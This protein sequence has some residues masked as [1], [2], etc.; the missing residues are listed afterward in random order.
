MRK[1][2][3]MLFLVLFLGCTMSTEQK[4]ALA[5]IAITAV[6]MTVDALIDSAGKY[7][8]RYQNRAGTG[9]II[10]Y[11]GFLFFVDD[12]KITDVKKVKE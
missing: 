3:V 1:I 11:P 7:S 2:I 8:E 6:G 12:G 5:E 10:V 4:K 9:E